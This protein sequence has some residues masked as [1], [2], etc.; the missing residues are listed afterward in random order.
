MLGAIGRRGWLLF[1]PWIVSKCV[2]MV[3][4]YFVFRLQSNSETKRQGE[5]VDDGGK[6]VM[7]GVVLWRFDRWSWI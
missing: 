5:R 3:R 2:G 7:E 6:G 1:T 4:W